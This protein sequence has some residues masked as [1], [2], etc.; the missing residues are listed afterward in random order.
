MRPAS[1]KFHRR[2]PRNETGEEKEQ[3]Q[4][5][6]LGK[7]C[8]NA[9]GAGR[10]AQVWQARGTCTREPARSLQR[11]R[12]KEHRRCSRRELTRLGNRNRENPPTS[13]QP[14]NNRKFKQEMW[15]SPENR[16]GGERFCR[17]ESSSPTPF[18]INA[19]HVTHKCQ[20][21]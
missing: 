3:T 10:N 4:S 20:Q 1:L 9:E 18:S 11:S 21:V 15:K 5:A 6:S 16:T 14:P 19:R 13:H 8:R 2:S 7:A 12:K 17:F